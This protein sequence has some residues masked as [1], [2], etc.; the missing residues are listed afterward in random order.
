MVEVTAQVAEL[1]AVVAMAEV[2]TALVKEAVAAILRVLTDLASTVLVAM[3]AKREEL[4]VEVMMARGVEV[5][6]WASLEAE[7]SVVLREA[8][9]V[10]NMVAEW[11]AMEVEEVIEA[12]QR[13]RAYTQCHHQTPYRH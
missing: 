8:A 1:A 6:V 10:A 3:V 9:E 5:R 7:V 13:T 11:A 12:R 2:A 4:M